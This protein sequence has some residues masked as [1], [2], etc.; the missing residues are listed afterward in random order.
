MYYKNSSVEW[1]TPFDFT[2]AEN[3]K[4]D[5]RVKVFPNPVTAEIVIETTCSFE[6]TSLNCIRSTGSLLCMKC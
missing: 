3:Y 6:P 5:N 2:S 4:N 1:G